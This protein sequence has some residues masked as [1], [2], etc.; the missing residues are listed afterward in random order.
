MKAKLRDRV[1]EAGSSEESNSEAIT[2][3]SRIQGVGKWKVYS[4]G[5]DITEKSID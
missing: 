2:I 5:L 3:A 4:E 1:G